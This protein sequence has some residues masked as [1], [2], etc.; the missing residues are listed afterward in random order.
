[1]HEVS[2]IPTAD[3]RGP[4][5]FVQVRGRLVAAPRALKL[6]GKRLH[7]L[8]FDRSPVLLIRGATWQRQMETAFESGL[9]AGQLIPMELDPLPPTR[10]HLHSVPTLP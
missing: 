1:V 7:L 4:R 2:M 5:R 8:I 10:H 3:T 6:R 9:R